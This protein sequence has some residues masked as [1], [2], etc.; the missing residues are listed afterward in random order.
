LINIQ[1]NEQRGNEQDEYA[2]QNMAALEL[3][4]KP[5]EENL[6]QPVGQRLKPPLD[7]F[8]KSSEV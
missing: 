6:V 3:D 7:D 1:S 2:E 5:L 4:A 8:R